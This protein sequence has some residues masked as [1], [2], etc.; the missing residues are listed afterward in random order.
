MTAPFTA[1][2]PRGEAIMD[3]IAA[4]PSQTLIASDF[5]GTLA[6]IVEDPTAAHIHPGAREAFARLGGLVGHLAIVTGRGL[7]SVRELGRLDEGEG[8]GSLLVQAQYGVESWNAG[9][10]EVSEPPLPPQIGQA[11]AQVQQLLAQLADEGYDVEGVGLEDKG[12]ALGVHTRRT[13]DPQGILNLLQEPIARMAEDLG[14]HLEPGRMVWELRATPGTKGQA[15]DTVLEL[16]GSRIAVMIGD[17]LADLTAFDRLHELERTEGLT[18]A[19]I[20]SASAG[21]QPVVAE[22]ADVLCEGPAGVAEWL[23]ALADRIEAASA[24]R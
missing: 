8:L 15:L 11:K 19:A 21:E 2:T 24:G 1:T 9:T 23:S 7:A 22:H 4:N 13:R 16:T 3:A 18:V 20:A 6:P 12:R 14:L 5:D 10:G 17:D